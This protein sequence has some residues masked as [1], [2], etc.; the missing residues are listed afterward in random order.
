MPTPP[1]AMGDLTATPVLLGVGAFLLMAVLVVRRVR[2]AI[3]IG[4]GAATAASVLLGLTGAPRSVVGLPDGPFAL[5]FRFDFSA[6]A[7][8]GFL[9]VLLVVFVMDFLDTMGTLIG[10]SARAGFLDERGD[11]PEIEKP[12]LCDA[13]A[14]VAGACAGTTTTGTFLESAAGIEAG[15][16]TG[17]TA[18]VTAL[19]FLPLLLF[20]PLLEVIPR[21]AYMPAL[22]LV[23]VLMMKP[24]ARIAYDDMTEVVPAFATVALMSFTFNL[25]VGMT[26]GLVLWPLM[27]LVTGR[28]R[29]I[30]LA[31]LP[32]SAI[33]LLFFVFYPYHG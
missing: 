18:V 4:I 11:L 12:L 30:P 9:Q 7:T 33:S 10:V 28:A 6:V 25:G 15:G 29:E 32:L 8:W 31:L 21:H 14:T 22:V 5:A 24:A 2:G 13:V 26:A 19:L 16:R 20:A 17:L 27:K 3:L 1:V 23:G